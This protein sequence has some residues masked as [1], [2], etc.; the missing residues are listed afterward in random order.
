M[1]PS[2]PE[3]NIR[4]IFVLRT[5]ESGNEMKWREKWIAWARSLTFQSMKIQDS[6][7]KQEIKE[8]DIKEEDMS[9]DEPLKSRNKKRKAEDDR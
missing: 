1:H 3:C 4:F 5:R 7:V 9:G 6:D 8:E 2:W